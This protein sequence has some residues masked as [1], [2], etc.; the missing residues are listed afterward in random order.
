VSEFLLDT[1]V[2]SEFSKRGGAD[3]VVKR[4][5]TAADDLSLYT[6]VLTLAEIRRGI[7]LLETGKRRSEL[8]HWLTNDLRPSLG[9]RVLAVSEAIG[10]RWAVLSVQLQRKG[11][12]LAT[13]DGLITATALEHNLTVV[14]RNVRDFAQSGVQLVNPWEVGSPT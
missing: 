11:I 9:N 3:P 10:G 5:L 1:N 13:I 7:E 8:E 2:L 14:T 6:S 4:W 12:T